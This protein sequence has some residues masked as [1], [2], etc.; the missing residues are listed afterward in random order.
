[1]GNKKKAEEGGVKGETWS[2]RAVIRSLL[3]KPTFACNCLAVGRFSSV[4]SSQ[5][6]SGFSKRIAWTSL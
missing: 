4:N 1:M 6:G 2:T 5:F 3:K